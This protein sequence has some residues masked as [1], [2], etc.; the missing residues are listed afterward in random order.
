LQG[1]IHQP[2]FEFYTIYGPFLLLL[3]LANYPC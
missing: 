2:T 3:F 1:A